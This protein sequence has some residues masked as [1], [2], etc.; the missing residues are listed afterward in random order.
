MKKDIET[1]KKE[2]HNE[3]NNYKFSKWTWIIF[4][5]G[6]L[7]MIYG[8]I[9]DIMV[10]FQLSLPLA[11]PSWHSMDA[12]V[13]LAC[14]IFILLAAFYLIMNSFKMKSIIKK[15]IETEM[16]PLI[17]SLLIA[18]IIGI[19]ADFI[20]GYYARGFFIGLLGLMY[21]NYKL[22]KKKRY[23]CFSLIIIAIIVTGFIWTGGR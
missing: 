16:K 9:L 17:K 21:L 19:I 18:C 23:L 3:N 2:T 20:A 5:I 12:R 1:N 10:Y 8:G 22:E 13:S 7:F 11:P 4:L 14:G 6:G 15:R